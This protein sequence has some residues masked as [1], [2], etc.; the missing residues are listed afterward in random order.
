MFAPQRLSLAILL[1]VTASLGFAGLAAAEGLNV[2][3]NHCLGQGTG[4]Q[5]ESFACD[6]NDGTHLMTG[7]FVLG[8]AVNQTI[9]LEI[10][11]DLAA[12]SPSLP[13]W[14]DLHNAGSCRDGC[15]SP[16]RCGAA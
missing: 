15:G 6:T 10:I 11:I 2:A 12:A 8:A 4:A 14:W 3:W 1:L 9:G 13:A 7:S 16:R 5:N